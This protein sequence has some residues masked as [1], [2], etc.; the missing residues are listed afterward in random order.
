M[1][2]CVCVCVRERERERECV[3]VC[4]THTC[5]NTHTHTHTHTHL[6]FIA[7]GH[8]DHLG[9]LLVSTLEEALLDVRNRVQGYVVL[10]VVGL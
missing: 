7:Q 3:R 5:R 4:I 6:V 9:Q 8:G 2:V 10:Y 1:Y